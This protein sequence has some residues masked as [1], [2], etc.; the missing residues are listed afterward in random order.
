MTLDLPMDAP[1]I[2]ASES[3]ANASEDEVVTASGA[4]VE[5]LTMYAGVASTGYCKSVVPG[6]SWNC[7]QCLQWVPDGKVVSSFTSTLSDT[8]GFILRSDEQKTLYVVFRGTSSFKSAITDLVFV[9]TDYTP[10]EGAKVHAGS[11]NRLS[12]LPGHRHRSLT[13]WSPGLAGRYGSLSTRV[14]TVQ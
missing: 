2:E 10:V 9:L 12:L 11:T 1:S 3:T 14:K 5:V 7:T 6:N 13:G 8:H 4:Q